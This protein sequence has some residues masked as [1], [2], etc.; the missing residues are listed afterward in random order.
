MTKELAK[1][2]VHYGAFQYCRD[3][4]DYPLQIYFADFVEII[5]RDKIN[6]HR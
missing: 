6:A 5:D 2:E 4:Y 1:K 3:K